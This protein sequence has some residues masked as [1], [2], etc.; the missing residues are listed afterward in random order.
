MKLM[1]G[2]IVVVSSLGAAAAIWFVSS[3]A[4]AIETFAS[5]ESE[6]ENTSLHTHSHDHDSDHSTALQQRQNIMT[7]MD[8]LA[9][10]SLG[11]PDG[12][13][14]AIQT[15]TWSWMLDV[16]LPHLFDRFELVAEHYPNHPDVTDMVEAAP[17]AY[18]H[19]RSKEDW[20]SSLNRL[21]T[22]TKIDHT[23][24]MSLQAIGLIHMAGNDL[25][26]AK[27][28]FARL[29]KMAQADPDAIEAAKEFIYEIDH[30]QIGMEAPA[31]TVKT[32]E[33]KEVSLASLRGKAVLLNFW[34]SW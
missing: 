15:L 21:A 29:I 22:T 31:F 14:I 1:I 33:G 7:K 20:I 4:N 5:L 25:S 2:L 12:A 10:S 32:L 9:K 6:M 27:E 19:S 28:A 16:D 18:K 8:A 24:L 17:I 23:R 3:N 13:H 34:A 26:H 30:L 11:T